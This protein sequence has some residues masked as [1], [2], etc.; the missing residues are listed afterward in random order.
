MIIMTMLQLRNNCNICKIH[1]M[2]H[3]IV[4]IKIK[5]FIMITM[6]MLQLKN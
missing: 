1:N 4:K 6:S 5:V 2:F 3:M